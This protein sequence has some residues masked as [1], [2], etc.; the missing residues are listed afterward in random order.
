MITNDCLWPDNT[1]DTPFFFFFLT[2]CI[3]IWGIF[4]SKIAIQQYLIWRHEICGKIIR[5]M[6]FKLKCASAFPIGLVET[7]LQ[8]HT[9][10]VSVW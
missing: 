10:T 9:P 6:V 2:K 7:D 5:S 1:S 3:L 4:H 8:G